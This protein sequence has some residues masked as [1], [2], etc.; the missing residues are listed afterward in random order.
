VNQ[1]HVFFTGGGWSYFIELHDINED[2][3]LVVKYE[4]GL[5]YRIISLMDSADCTWMNT[6]KRSKVSY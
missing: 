2:N 1:P 3:I 4:G 6:M 5:K